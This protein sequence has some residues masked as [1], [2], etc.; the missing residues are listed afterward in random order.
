MAGTVRGPDPRLIE[1]LLAEPDSFEF[2]QAVR[3]LLHRLHADGRDAALR[4]SIGS[5]ALLSRAS[6]D[7]ASASIHHD[8]HGPATASLVVTIFGLLGSAG[9]LPLA[10]QQSIAG[11][12]GTPRQATIAFLNVIE[13]RLLLLLFV[14]IARRHHA[15]AAELAQPLA[16]ELG[17]RVDTPLRRLAGIGLDALEGRLAVH[18]DTATAYV[19]RLAETRRSAEGLADVLSSFLGTPV[20]IRQ[21]VPRW[22]DLGAETCAALRTPRVGEPSPLG[23]GNGATLGTTVREGEG[24]VEVAVQHLEFEQFQSLLPG[25]A[26]L[27]ALADLIRLYA[28]TDL[29]A[30]ITLALRPG[31]A[32]PTR[33]GDP[34]TPSRLGWDLWLGDRHPATIPA[35]VTVRDPQ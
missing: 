28:P 34:H 5:D 20:R 25:T 23:L 17:I 21:F 26:G 8:D 6:G 4:L 13:Q 33:L 19:G 18:D 35:P 32:R 7:V 29:V 11:A 10:L 30:R 12:R 3:L 24:L 2:V 27:R 14:A 15:L 9:T 1:T 22:I 16:T 31:E